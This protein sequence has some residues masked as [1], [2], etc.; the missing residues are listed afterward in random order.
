MSHRKQHLKTLNTVAY[1]LLLTEK[2]NMGRKFS[3]HHSIQNRYGTTFS[4]PVSTLSEGH[5]DHAMKLLIHHI[6]VL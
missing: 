2:L 5:R 4:Q 3:V 6:L 1:V